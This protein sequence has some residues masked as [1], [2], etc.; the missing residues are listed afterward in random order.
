MIHKRTTHSKRIR[1]GNK[2]SWDD[3]NKNLIRFNVKCSSMD[4]ARWFILYWN[5]GQHSQIQC[6]WWR[7]VNVILVSVQN[8]KWIGYGFRR[9]FFLHFLFS[10]NKYVYKCWPW[11]TEEMCFWWVNML[12]VSKCVLLV[13]VERVWAF[14]YRVGALSDEPQP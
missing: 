5:C 6:K 11:K 8:N 4:N 9:F 14:W 7:Y 3:E 2:V 10:N 1:L 12:L 13:I